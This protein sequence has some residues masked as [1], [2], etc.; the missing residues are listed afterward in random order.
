MPVPSKIQWSGNEHTQ[1]APPVIGAT[2]F[3][4]LQALFSNYTVFWQLP[5]GLVI[6]FTIVLLRGGL[7]D[8]LTR[9]RGKQKGD[10]T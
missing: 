5:L 1:S 9:L 10:A 7:L 2:V 3:L 4:V 8:L 6:I